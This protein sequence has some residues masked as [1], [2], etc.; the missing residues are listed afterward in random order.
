MFMTRAWSE[1]LGE[2]SLSPESDFFDLGGDSLLIT[3]LGRKINQEFDIKVPIRALLIERTL[4]R[5]S[6]LVERLVAERDRQDPSRSGP[7]DR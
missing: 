5:Q 6:D 1:L 7:A 4:G 3:R 2:N